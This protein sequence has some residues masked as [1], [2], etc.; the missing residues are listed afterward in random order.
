MQKALAVFTLRI[1]GWCISGLSSATELLQQPRPAHSWE[2]LA[3]GCVVVVSMLSLEQ[4]VRQG[5]TAL[6]EA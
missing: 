1:T 3:G 6:L 4:P 2:W 5:L